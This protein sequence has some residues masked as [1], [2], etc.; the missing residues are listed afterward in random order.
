LEEKDFIK[1]RSALGKNILSFDE[2]SRGNPGVADGGGI[3]QGPS[4]M[5]EVSYSW[6]LYIETNNMAEALAL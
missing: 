2:A 1:W 6:G 4:G 5:L 3:L